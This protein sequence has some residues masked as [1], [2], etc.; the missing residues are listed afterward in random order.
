MLPKL[1][2]A[3]VEGLR[4]SAIDKSES[5]SDK[6]PVK[7]IF[8]VTSVLSF[9]EIFPSE[10]EITPVVVMFI[11][12]VFE[13]RSTVSPMTTFPSESEITPVVVT[14]MPV[15]ADPISTVSSSMR[16]ESE[17]EIVPVIDRLP[18]RE[19]L[20]DKVIDDDPESITI[21]PVVEPPRFNV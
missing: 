10:S 20:S 3:S 7:V 11:P 13:P 17:S 14:F 15:V 2:V 5:E 18:E 16:F 8:P 21:F 19:V 1:Y 6:V 9:K 12:V 4:W